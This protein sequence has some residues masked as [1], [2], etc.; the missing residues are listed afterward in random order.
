MKN[1]VIG[2]HQKAGD[3]DMKRLCYVFA[4]LLALYAAPALAL[5]N[6]DSGS[7]YDPDRAGEGIN[8]EVTDSTV[9]MYFYTYS[10][11]SHAFYVGVGDNDDELVELTLYETVP[12]SLLEFP[13]EE[14]EVGTAFVEKE[15]GFLLWSYHLSL[16]ADKVD[17]G[18]L[19]YCVGFHCDG[20]FVYERL[21]Q[22]VACQ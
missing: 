13:K 17:N 5:E 20:E 21:T 15:E 2:H 16:D 22:P 7:W 19:P 6:C 10:E 1:V 12:G 11:G 3:F 8:L 14:L 18:H 4:A 9:V